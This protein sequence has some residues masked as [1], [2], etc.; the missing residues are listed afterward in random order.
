MAIFPFPYIAAL[1]I[2]FVVTWFAGLFYIVRLFIYHR[3]ADKKPEPER[4]ILIN[5]FKGAEKRLWY[6]IT[7]PSMIGVYI[8]GFWLYYDIY[9]FN[10]PGWLSIKLAFIFGLTLYHL[11]CGLILKHFQK[12]NMKYSSFKLRLWNEVATLFLV[13]IVFI[14]VLKDQGNWLWGIVGLAIFTILLLMGI[15]VYRKKREKI[16][17]DIEKK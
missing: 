14:V 1:H 2:I 12:G 8:F 3:E 6:G 17:Q 11:Q 13:A 5:H 7:W 15:Y 16:E 9:N 10:F 4:S